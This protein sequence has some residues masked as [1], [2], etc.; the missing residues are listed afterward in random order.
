MR[1][2]PG[3]PLDPGLVGEPQRHPPESASTPESIRSTGLGEPR[4]TRRA[5][6]ALLLAAA[7]LLL[8]GLGWTDVSAPDEPRYLQVAEEMRAFE[9]GPAGLVLLHLNGEPYTQKPPLYYGLAALAGAPFGRVSEAAGR[10]PS[11]LAGL[12]TVVLTAALGTRLFGTTAG[13][14]GAAL[15]LTT[16]EFSNLARRM[17]LDVL[18]TLFE[19]VALA[20][21]W[22]VDRRRLS[23]ARGALLFHLALA[24]GVLTKGPVGFLL[25]VLSVLGFLAWERRLGDARRLFPI[26]GLAISILPGIAWI[27]GA[28][29]LA[30]AGF[31]DQAVTTNLIG[32]FFDGTSH[33]RPFYYYL[34]QF[35]V[36]FLPWTI[37]LPAVVWAA[38]RR[39]FAAGS[40]DADTRRA[41]RFLLSWLLAS[42]FF[43]SVSSGKRGLYMLPAFPAAAL[44]CAH[45]LRFWIERRGKLPTAL[46]RTLGV[47]AGLIGGVGLAA[48]V[49]GSGV[50]LP[51]TL[52]EFREAV[53]TPKL[54]GFGIAALLAAMLGTLAFRRVAAARTEPLAAFLV[55][56]VAAF[57]IEASIFALLLP[58]LDPIR[59]PRPIAE[60]A[61]A[62]TPRDGRIGLYREQP[63]IGGLVYYGG[64]RV[65]HLQTKE[66]VAAFVA[67]GG[68]AIVVK[69]RKLERLE[70]I[71]PVEVVTRIRPGRR[72]IVIAAPV[73]T[74]PAG[75][76]AE[77]FRAP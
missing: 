30:P 17:Q 58:A 29:N 74:A 28:I 8:V 55:A 72:E 23:A 2:P 75:A 50:P 42:L 52:I 39:V 51:G 18:L 56:V 68:R 37:L 4:G 35:P 57:A 59:T 46:V 64:R 24:L 69:G 19:T 66:D 36:D 76:P 65:A 70:A 34:Y 53:N 7:V 48:L 14:L 16:F 3:N 22:A 49:L 61:A 20:V 5:R 77:A 21:F 38:R 9:H 27:W 10:L 45:S 15:L 60:A 54:L 31:A 73:L 40:G 47:G 43:F 33:D 32:R 6:A 1:N 71:T 25:P 12:A 13:L 67:A 11:A 41:W 26:W 62:I 44:L 63:M